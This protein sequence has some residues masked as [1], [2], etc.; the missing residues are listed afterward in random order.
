MKRIT[1]VDLFAG[2]GGFHYALAQAGAECVFAVE[3]DQD[4]RW[5]YEQNFRVLSPTLWTGDDG[6]SQNFASDITQV[7]PR[8]LPA[9]DVLCAG[10][11]CQPFSISGSQR[12]FRDTRGTLFFN[13]MEIVKAKQPAVVFLEN[14]KNLIYHDGGN[15]L[16]VIIAE[17]EQAG[18][19]VAW[20]VLNAKDFGLAQ[21]R[22]R[23]IIVGHREQ[24]FDFTQIQTVAPQT[25]RQILDQHGDGEYLPA[26][27][28]TILA[29][30]LWK[31]QSSGLIFCGYR[32]KAIRKAG[33]RPHTEHLSRVHKQANRI[34]HADGTHPTVSAQETSGRFWIYDD[35]GVRK[36]TLREVYRLQ[37]FPDTF[38][39]NPRVTAA[40]RQIGNAVAI[41][42]IAAVYA[43]IE[44]QFFNAAGEL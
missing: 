5:T 12:G 24:S 34:Y 22:E 26:A 10:F 36:L 3:W 33:T 15:T 8:Q 11:P 25:I 9:H 14:V 35:E 13:I 27:E 43:Q 37:G 18:Y 30:D 31:T 7:N 19:R 28:Y 4:C 39:K 21:A 29:R 6:G 17:L 1:F 38:V 41:P 32:N 44:A 42:M 40:Y 2:I 16:R 23:I 20:R